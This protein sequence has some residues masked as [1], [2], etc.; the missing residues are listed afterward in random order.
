[1]C[2]GTTS[3]TL[4]YTATTGSPN[5]YQID[6]NAAANTAG[7]SDVAW[8]A[9]PASPLTITSTG[10]AAT[11]TYNGVVQVR[12]SA[13]VNTS[14]TYPFTVT[15]VAPPSISAQPGN[16]SQCVGTNANFS[17][18][19]SGTGL[20]Y[21]WRKGGSNITGATTSAYTISNIQ[22]TDAGSFD[23]VIS[24][25]NCSA[26]SNAATLTVNVLPTI[27]LGANPSVCKGT[28]TTSLTYSATTGS[29]DQYSVNYNATAEA[30]GFLDVTNIA[31]P[32]TI[33]LTVPANPSVITYSATLTVR[34]S[35]TSCISSPS[36]SISITV[37]PLPDTGPVYHIPNN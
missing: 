33:S 9:L 2:T 1:M 35:T 11:G 7:F 26:T 25:G 14:I 36:N 27:T 17:V 16:L 10:L 6:F 13:P 21:Q 29:P 19:A 18:T 30:A 4:P 8:T 12:V 28:T 22:T 37:N 31:L 24:S 32:G 3:S 15:V 34:N 5:Q 23:V 20:T